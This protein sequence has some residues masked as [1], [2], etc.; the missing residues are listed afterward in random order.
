MLVKTIWAGIGHKFFFNFVLIGLKI[1]LIEQPNI[2]V[3]G[4]DSSI[5]L[6]GNS[7]YG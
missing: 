5:N 2:G 6:R 3:G 1:D 4:N 7:S